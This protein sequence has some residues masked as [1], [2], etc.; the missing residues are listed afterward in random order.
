M[1]DESQVTQDKMISRIQALHQ[2]FSSKCHE[3]KGFTIDNGPE[4]Q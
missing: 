1:G 4:G 3:S 2:T